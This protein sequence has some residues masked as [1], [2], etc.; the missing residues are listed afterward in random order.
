MKTGLATILLILFC[1]QSFAF[2]KESEGQKT[3]N[4][5]TTAKRNYELKAKSPDAIRQEIAERRKE[6]NSKVKDVVKYAKESKLSAAWLMRSIESGAV[7]QK[8]VD[9]N[10]KEYERRQQAA[11]DTEPMFPVPVKMAIVM[12]VFSIIGVAYLK[13]RKAINNI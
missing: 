8:L 10:Q 1:A 5:I 9:K 6:R 4:E 12:A 13:I 7:S 11:L 3:V 2:F